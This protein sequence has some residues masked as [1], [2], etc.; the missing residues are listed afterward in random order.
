MLRTEEISDV[1]FALMGSGNSRETVEAEYKVLKHVPVVVADHYFTTD[2]DEGIPPEK[3][4]GVKHVFDDVPTKK[5][6]AQDTTEDGWTNFDE[7]T[8]TRK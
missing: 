7:S 2:D 3:Y 5:V 6:D 8:A 1:D 4:Q